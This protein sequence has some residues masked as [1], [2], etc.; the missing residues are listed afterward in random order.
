VVAPY[1]SDDTLTLY[2][3]EARDV[4]STLDAGSVQCVV[5][6]PP[7]FGLRDYAGHSEQI[8]L[9]ST[10]GEYVD[11]LMRVFRE[12]HR[13][14][15]KDG[16][17]W[18]NLGDSY[19]SAPPGPRTSSGLRGTSQ[20]LTTPQGFGD[21]TKAGLPAKNLIGI[22]WR[23]AFALQED[24]WYLRNEIIWY[25]PNAMPESVTDRLSC[26]HETVFM[27]TKSRRYLFDLD[28]IRAPLTY[29]EAL[30][31][32]IVFGGHAEGEGKV[33]GSARRGGQHR[34][35]YGRTL[36]GQD[37][38]R[39]S[40]MDPAHRHVHPK[41]RNPGD[42]WAINT[43]PLPEAHFAA[44][45]VDLPRLCIL[46]GCPTG[47]VVLDPFSGAGTTALAAQELGR[48]AIGIDLNAAYHDIALRRMATAPLPFGDGG[49]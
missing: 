35:V 12:L 34:S 32:G 3:G 41:G 33:G 45:P 47:G 15:A 46:A 23:V 2:V 37:R 40:D 8:G 36:P 10:P 16:T 48:K 25:K 18:L 4:L 13:V 24:G 7:Y 43:R 38:A 39:D 31:R 20:A 49:A 9:E 22:P 11:Q 27:L 6:S 26:K 5:T 19:V 44:F 14:L 28:P 17:F 1:Y 42:V 29:P 30:S 21:K